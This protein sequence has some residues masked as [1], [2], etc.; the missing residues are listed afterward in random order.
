MAKE[1]R[2]YPL[3]IANLTG[4][5]I[6]LDEEP[7]ETVPIDNILFYIKWFDSR[8]YQID[9]GDVSIRQEKELFTLTNT[10][11]YSRETD[12]RKKENL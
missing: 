8:A 5:L 2:I 12:L 11:L 9:V 1:T 3:D 4:T 6:R 10:P 7:S